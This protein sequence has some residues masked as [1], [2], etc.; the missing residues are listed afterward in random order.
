MPKG[1]DVCR[2]GNFSTS[3]SAA[4]HWAEA[5]HPALDGRVSAPR[6][7]EYHGR[8]LAELLVVLTNSQSPPQALLFKTTMLAL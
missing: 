6:P 3:W 4:E 7:G 5:P 2:T 1:C 8:D